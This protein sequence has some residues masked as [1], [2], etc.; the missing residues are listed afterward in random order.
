MDKIKIEENT[1]A[2]TL[3]M[4]L[5]GRAQCSKQYPKVFKDE[6]AERIIDSIDYDFSQLNY[7]SFVILSWAIRKKFFCDCAI[8][9][10]SEHPNATIVNLGCGVDTSFAAVDNGTC[11]F[12][13]L[14]LPEVIAAREQFTKCRTREKNLA[15]SAFDLSWL[16]QVETSP[17][18][19]LLIMSGGVLFYFD[20]ATLKPLF[21]AVAE[22]FPKSVICFDA[23]N[24]S[25]LKKSN[26]VVE[27][28]GNKGAKVILALDNPRKQLSSWTDK[29]DR[30]NVI[31]S[32]DPEIK[33]EKSIP[34]IQRISVNIGLKLGFMQFVE[35]RFK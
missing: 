33:N 27:K 32:L 1:V 9:Y 26:K 10:L 7:K 31:R 4:P 11:R 20:E 24:S 35:V 34:F 2:E 12:I 22:R 25:G 13:N 19:G 5:Y 14:D 30:V 28:S 18:D 17:E 16:D 8:A 3:I 23:V 6:D 29:I 15:S 21:N